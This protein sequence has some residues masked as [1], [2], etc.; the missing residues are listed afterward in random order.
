MNV[1]V[2]QKESMNT[3][4]L[5][6]VWIFEQKSITTTKHTHTHRSTSTNVCIHTQTS[7]QC[8]VNTHSNLVIFMY[9][10]RKNPTETFCEFIVMVYGNLVNASLTVQISL[11]NLTFC[12]Q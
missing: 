9:V 7:K 11:A 2:I 6:K 10:E 8:L 3:H 1:L 4:I 5:K 12:K